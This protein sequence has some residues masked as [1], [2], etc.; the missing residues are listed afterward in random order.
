MCVLINPT[1]R[2]LTRPRPGFNDLNTPGF[3]AG[4]FTRNQGFGSNR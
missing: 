3:T 4:S 2:I 1:L